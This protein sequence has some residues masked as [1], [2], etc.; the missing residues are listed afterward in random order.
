[1]HWVLFTYHRVSGGTSNHEQEASFYGLRDD[2]TIIPEPDSGCGHG[3]C[4]V[5]G[6][7]DSPM[8]AESFHCTSV[9]G[10]EQRRC[11]NIPKTND[12]KRKVIEFENV[13]SRADVCITDQS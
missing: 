10:M 5:A 13:S 11:S 12:F 7:K 9:A 2:K 4:D 6:M 1:M 8:P 3:G